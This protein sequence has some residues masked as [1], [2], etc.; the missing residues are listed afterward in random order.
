[1]EFQLLVSL[2][3]LKYKKVLTVFLIQ[4]KYK[5]HISQINRVIATTQERTTFKQFNY[6]SVCILK[7]LQS[8][9]NLVTKR[10]SF[11]LLDQMCQNLFQQVFLHVGQQQNFGNMTDYKIVLIQNRMHALL[12]Q[13]HISHRQLQK[14]NKVNIYFKCNHFPAC[15]L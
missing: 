7:N 6:R 8:Y 10:N 2:Y 4:K 1:M 11:N 15:L 9:Q 5:L 12:Q 3:F 14:S 13:F